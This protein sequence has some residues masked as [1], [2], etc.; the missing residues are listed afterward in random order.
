VAEQP[1]DAPAC[2][3]ALNEAEARFVVIGGMAVVLQ[4]SA[5]VTQDVDFCFS[6]ERRNVQ[7][8]AQALAPFHPRPYMMDPSL[9][10]IWDEQ[11]VRN[12]TTLTLDTDLGRVD[13]LAE[14]DGIDSFEGLYA[15]A[16]DMELD[17]HPVKVASLDD[18]I[19]M[20]RAAGRP[21]DLLAIM[22]LEAIK[23]LIE[24]G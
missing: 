9:P 12:S 24:P 23:G 2:V 11:T 13:F 14:P 20:K 1:L 10:F 3:K 22:D 16:I 5:Y 18:L 8:I 19:S 4:G 6:R 7:A 21:K 17:G 15:R